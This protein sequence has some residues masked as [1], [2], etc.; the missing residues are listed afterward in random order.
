VKSGHLRFGF[1]SSALGCRIVV[2]STLPRLRPLRA[3]LYVRS[4]TLLELSR[5]PFFPL[6][7]RGSGA[8]P[9]IVL[10]RRHE[11]DSHFFS[12]TQ[13]DYPKR[14]IEAPRKG[15]SCCFPP[16]A[17][18]TAGVPFLILVAASCAAAT[19]RTLKGPRHCA[20]RGMGSSI[21]GRLRSAKQEAEG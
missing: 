21:G 14:G 9:R 13:E 7:R 5:L 1:D 3:A 20:R 19:K 10:F 2:P 11:I 4:V 16:R 18:K 15:G 6:L 12:L 17:V 8:L